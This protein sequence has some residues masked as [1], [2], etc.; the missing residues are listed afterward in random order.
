ME[1]VSDAGGAQEVTITMNHNIN[2]PGRNSIQNDPFNSDED[3]IVVL[4]EQM[5]TIK[6]LIAYL[7]ELGELEYAYEIRG[8]KLSVVR[9]SF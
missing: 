4:R 8:H 7:Q 6:Q 3:T 2:R 1:R 5:E 9:V